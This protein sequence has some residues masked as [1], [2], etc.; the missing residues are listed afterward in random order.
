MP[1]AN[2]SGIK[3][4]SDALPQMNGAPTAGSASTI[5]RGDHAH[6]YDISRAPKVKIL[7]AGDANLITS[8]LIRRYLLNGNLTDTSGSACNLTVT[9]GTARYLFD[10]VMGQKVFLF[11]SATY[12]SAA[13]TNL[14]VGN[15]PWSR[16]CW[17]QGGTTL[18]SLGG[19]GVEGN[20]TRTN[21]HIRNGS[22]GGNGHVC[23][24][25]T[26][27]GSIT[28]YDTGVYVVGTGWHCLGW[29]NTGT[30]QLIYI[31]GVLQLTLAITRAIT[32]STY[33]RLGAISDANIYLGRYKYCDDRVYNRALTADEMAAIASFAG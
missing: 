26:V 22:Y 7:P 21:W 13:K 15:S 28:Y 14:P 31:N 11:D 18:T 33:Y 27:T 12:L 9:A 6:P 32:A 17:Y 25:I 5:S 8:G 4:F 20:N 16:T 2:V 19:W 29:V 24:G 10:A 1:Y 3:N 30:S 23:A